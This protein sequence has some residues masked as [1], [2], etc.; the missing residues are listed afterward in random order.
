MGLPYRLRIVVPGSAIAVLAA[1]GGAWTSLS[2]FLPAAGPNVAVRYLVSILL[3]PLFLLV[4]WMRSWAGEAG[5]V[6]R[7]VSAIA[8]IAILAI[9]LHPILPR[10]WTAAVTIVGLAAWLFCELLLVAAPA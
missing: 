4:P 8:V 5:A 1:I 6:P 2:S 10:R 3:A 7:Y 9:P